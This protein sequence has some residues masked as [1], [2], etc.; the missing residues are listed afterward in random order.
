MVNSEKINV[1]PGGLTALQVRVKEISEAQDAFDALVRSGC[2][3]D[4]LWR[5]LEGVFGMLENPVGGPRFWR[6]F[7]KDFPRRLADVRAAAGVLETLNG[8]LLGKVFLSACHA[9]QRE[10]YA[11]IPTLIR[12]YSDWLERS[13]TRFPKGLGKS[14]PIGALMQYIHRATGAW[15]DREVA[16]LL[17]IAEG[18]PELE[19]Q[20]LKGRRSD[21]QKRRTDL[22]EEA[23]G[24]AIFLSQ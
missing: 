2:K 11:A 1:H 21:W 10:C 17:A 24:L 14:L 12:G 8:S 18:I 20:E 23:G 6:G 16:D 5:V 22:W 3:A 4:M 19:A 15:H 13:W 9:R 7:G